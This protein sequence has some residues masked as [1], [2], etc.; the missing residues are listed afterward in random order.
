MIVPKTRP[1]TRVS[2]KVKKKTTRKKIIRTQERKIENP[3]LRGE[4]LLH[5]LLILSI[6]CFSIGVVVGAW[7]FRKIAPLR[8]CKVCDTPLWKK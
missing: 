3:P 4:R 1:R 6:F 2:K 7:A 5:V 8:R